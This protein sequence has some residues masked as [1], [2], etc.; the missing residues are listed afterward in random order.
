MEYNSTRSPLIMKE[1]GR[2]IQKMVDNLLTVKEKQ[3]P[4]YNTY[5]LIELIGFI[6]QHHN[7][8]EEY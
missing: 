6:M 4:Q 7:T 5:P 1:Y 3:E 2:H 8:V